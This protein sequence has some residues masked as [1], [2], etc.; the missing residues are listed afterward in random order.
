MSPRTVKSFHVFSLG[1]LLLV[2]GCDRDAPKGP[3]ASATPAPSPAPAAPAPKASATPP[4]GL[5]RSE[6]SQLF[7]QLSEPDREFFSDNLISNETSYLQVADA[8]AKLPH[9]RGAYL[10]V[11]PEQNFTY[12]ALLRPEL[13]FIV[14]IRRDNAIEQLL[15]KALFEMASSRTEF[16]A[17]LTGRRYEAKADPGASAPL[18]EILKTVRGMPHD[19]QDLDAAHDGVKRRLRTFGVALSGKDEKSLER[20]HR[21]F[22]DGGVDI[23]FELKEKNGRTYPTL[24]ELLSEKSPAGK[25]LGFLASESA[26]RSVQTLQK[27]NRI[28]PVVGDFAG[29]HALQA[30]GQELAK[31]DLPVLAFYVSNVEQ[32]VME[33]PQWKAWVKNVDALPSN[34]HSFFIRAY[35]DQG[36]RHPLQMPGHRTATVMTSFDHFK[37]RQRVRGYGSFWQVATDG[38]GDAGPG[39]GAP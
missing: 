39:Q 4:V 37:W 19:A 10:G 28:I 12:I 21:A 30:I 2:S 23:R 24:A 15:Y 29:E 14:D 34:E 18:D 27:E 3:A 31:R 36:R 1:A 32:Y 25:A 26:F 7:R 13:S 16:L 9:R 6:L 33:P 5:S 11:G 35:L 22:F 38:I 20:I 8:M 17:L